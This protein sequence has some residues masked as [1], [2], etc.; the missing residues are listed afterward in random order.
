MQIYPLNRYIS[1]HKIFMEHYF[2]KQILL[3]CSKDLKLLIFTPKISFEN[4]PNLD[5]ILEKV[6]ITDKNPTSKFKRCLH[7]CNFLYRR[8]LYF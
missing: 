4:I 7:P 8:R 5:T 2:P 6:F 1:K 3:F